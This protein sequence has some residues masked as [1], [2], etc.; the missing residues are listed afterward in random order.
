LDLSAYL[1]RIGFSFPP[2]ADLATLNAL[3]RLHANA[4]AFENLDVQLGNKL[5]TDVSSAFEKLVTRRRGGWCY[6]QNAVLG[7][8][9]TQIGFEVVRVSGGVMRETKGD[10][11]MGGHLCLIVTMEG[12]PWLAD[13]GFGNSLKAPMALEITERRDQPYDVGLKRLDDGYWRFWDRDGGEPFSFDFR[14][15]PADESLLSAKCQ[16]QQTNPASPFVQNLVVQRRR[17][18]RHFTLR[19]RVFSE[20]GAGIERTLQ[21]PAELVDVL[22]TH[23]DLDVREAA[24]LW[25]AICARHRALGLQEADLS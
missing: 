1:A 16:E 22:Q 6:E 4:I 3:H 23:F 11:Q 15:E 20:T 21:S 24:H 12:V 5:T 19:G 14:A 17:D 2:R 7:W 25:P 13:V 18:N 8:A 10:A 9:L